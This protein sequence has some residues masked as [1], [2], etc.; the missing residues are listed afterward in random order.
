MVLLAKPQKGPAPW[1]RATVGTIFFIISLFLWPLVDPSNACLSVDTTK[2]W[3]LLLLAPVHHENPWHLACNVAGLWLTGRRMEQSVGTGMFLVL[4]FSAALFAGFLHLAL[5]LVMELLFQE[6]HY[7][8]GCTLGFSGVLFAMQVMSSSE[9]SLV[10]DLLLC[11]AESLV[12]SYFAPKISF[13]GH[14]AG[15]LVGL[16]YTWGPLRAVTRRK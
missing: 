7:R 5:N 2:L 12:A 6:S 4:V 15:V 10:G 9:N 14:L 1:P 13:S 16:A 3:W 8:A 11:L